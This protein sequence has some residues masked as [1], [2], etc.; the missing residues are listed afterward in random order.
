MDYLAVPESTRRLGALTVVLSVNILGCLSLIKVEYA[1]EDSY[2]KTLTTPDGGVA[3]AGAELMTT[4]PIE[5]ALATSRLGRTIKELT[6]EPSGREAPTN[7][8]PKVS[9]Y[10]TLRVFGTKHKYHVLK[11]ETASAPGDD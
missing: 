4:D 11:V 10:G 5:T 3:T 7:I 2:G 1:T 9:D 8:L 6:E